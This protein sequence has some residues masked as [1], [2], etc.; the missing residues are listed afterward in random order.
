MSAFGRA[1]GVRQNR[2]VEGPV[3]VGVF[4]FAFAGFD[5]LDDETVNDGM[6]VAGLGLMLFMYWR[7]GIHLTDVHSATVDG[8][9]EKA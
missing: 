3:I 2:S 9:T 5:G 7:M 8:L 6:D 1:D 4:V